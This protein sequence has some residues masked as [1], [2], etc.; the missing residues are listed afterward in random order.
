MTEDDLN[1]IRSAHLDGRPDSTHW[2]ECHLAHPHCAIAALLSEVKQLQDH[3][4]AWGDHAMEKQSE[5]ERL[6]DD[7]DCREYA[8]Q[9]AIKD[10]LDELADEGVDTVNHPARE[11][12]GK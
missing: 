6:R 5:A 10:L 3:V 2:G 1:S 7:C 11:L 9:G 12:L 8:L 4:K